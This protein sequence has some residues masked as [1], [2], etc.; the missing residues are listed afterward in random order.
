MTPESTPILESLHSVFGFSSFREGQEPVVQHLLNGK[1][2]LAVFPTGSGKS[3]CYQLPALYFSGLTLVV[4]PLIALMKDQ[5]E[6]LKEFDIAAARLDSTLS[7][8][9]T[10]GV[11]LD[12]RNRKLKILF[13]APER[14]SNE[15][16]I[17]VL[18]GQ[19]IDLMVID[20]AHCISEW[21]HNFRP[22]YLKLAKMAMRLNAR[23]VLAL[24][25]TAT[26]KVAEDIC[27]EFSIEPEAFIHTGYYR[28]NLT[29]RF[30]VVQELQQRRELMLKR[31]QE[32]AKGPTIVYVTLQKTSE[33]IAYFLQSEGLPCRAYHA[34]MNNEDRNA[35]QDWFMA[36]D[37]AI[38]VAT[39][40]FGMGIDK[41]DIRYVYHYNLP[42]SL[43]N[44][45]QE[46]GRAGRDGLPS[47]CEIFAAHE[48]L[49]VLE[50]FIYG[51]TPEKKA[52]SEMLAF[53]FAQETL[54]DISVHELA[55]AFDIRPLVVNTLLTY[56]ELMNLLESTQPFYSSY[57]FQL[58]SSFE[59]IYLR[60]D[61]VRTEFLKKMFAHAVRAR[62]WFSIDLA[63]TA[64]AIQEDRDRL[65]RA[66][67]FLEEE[68]HLIL[69]TSGFRQGY[70]IVKTPDDHGLLEKKLYSQLVNNESLNITRLNHVIEL[71]N[72]S[73]CK[74]RFL[75]K[76]FGQNRNEDCGHCGWCLQ[77]K[78]LDFERNS[79]PFT[80]IG[81][82]QLRALF[83]ETALTSARQMARFL[84]GI[85]SPLITKKRLRKHPSFACLVEVPF[86]NVLKSLEILLD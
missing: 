77:E 85:T 20:E 56:L 36:S 1:S 8:E 65:I 11:H 74:V 24:T 80:G 32:N 52:V 83:E 10:K 5:V 48:D 9:E 30:H 70:R 22:E 72:H 54:F 69:Q 33:D 61:S 44:Y 18:Q 53:L 57:K 28:P 23:R 62:T 17:Q 35:V 40:A 63:H 26:R 31:V 4:S 34:G 84:C 55:N 86:A 43:E 6:F 16:F 42:K 49:I 19:M 68:G 15:R 67:Q 81:R 14:L 39:I 38:V 3:L 59:E 12:I 46:I 13:A 51:D 2:V 21:G 71:V 75:L 25:A 45:S 7:R 60:F 76:Y 47:A 82:E 58:K 64:E 37:S 79:V 73:G 41:S 78:N 27:R 66:L 50:N 29:I